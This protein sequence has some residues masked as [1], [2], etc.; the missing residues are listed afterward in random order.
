MPFTCS[1]CGKSFVQSNS[2]H[3]HL[4]RR[5][6][7]CDRK[8]VTCLTVFSTYNE[9]VNHKCQDNNSSESYKI[10]QLKLEQAK[11]ENET[12][13]Q[14]IELEKE[15]LK[16]RLAGKNRE[17]RMQDRNLIPIDDFN[18][19]YLPPI[20]NPL[21][22]KT[23]IEVETNIDIDEDGNQSI[24]TIERFERRRRYIKYAEKAEKAISKKILA[25]ALE[26]VLYNYNI[27]ESTLELL[28]MIHTEPKKT[29]LHSIKYHD[30]RK[31]TIAM[32]GRPPPE[33]ECRW[34]VNSFTVGQRRIEEH[35]L[36]TM[37]FIFE[38]AT[39]KLIPAYV[40]GPDY[41]NPKIPR[42]QVRYVPV[43]AMEFSATHHLVLAENMRRD[44]ELLV[45]QIE[46]DL[47]GECPEEEH[48]AI[49]AL[50][51]DLNNR[52]ARFLDILSKYEFA[53]TDVNDFLKLCK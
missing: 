35:A 38:S 4:N 13:R 34:I 49:I 9:F 29:S 43:L 46:N 45:I 50:Y 5:R 11:L 26:C 40:P 6:V 24:E 25:K 37:D 16:Y 48:P 10:A 36:G 44:T 53:K 3:A 1:K 27:L 14:E 21:N 23:R 30:P 20:F 18:S 17:R 28:T 51:D 32:F 22:S 47:I 2:L 39:R 31:M 52:K 15:K 41:F 7:P 33:E 12:R 19:S 42:D 8:C